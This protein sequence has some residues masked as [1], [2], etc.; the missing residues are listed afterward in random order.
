LRPPGDGRCVNIEAALEAVAEYTSQRAV[1][2]FVD[3]QSLEDRLR[4]TPEGV[5]LVRAVKDLD[6]RVRPTGN[7]VVFLASSPGVP[8]ELKDWVTLVETPLPDARE[9]LAIVQSWIEANCTSVACDLD[10]EGVHALGETMAGMTSRA[11]QSALAKSA[12]SRGGL[13]PCTVEDVLREKVSVIR[14][15]EVL[16]VVPVE[17]TIEDVGGLNNAKEFLVRRKQAFTSAAKRFGLPMF[18]G[19]LLVGVAGTGKSLLAKVTAS[20][21]QLPLL[22]FD[23]GRMQGSL[24]GQS[25][26]RMRRALLLAEAQAPVLL[27]VDEIEKAFAGVGG[28]AGDGGVLQRQFGYLLNWMQE[29]ESPVVII[30]TANDVRR[31][32]AEFLRKGRFDEIF[33]V[34]LPTAAERAEILSVVLSKYGQPTKGIVVDT[35]VRKLERFTGAEID[36]VVCEAL[37]DAFADQQR[38][39]SVADIER[40]AARTVPLADQ[41][42]DEISGLQQWGRVNARPAS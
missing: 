11:I 35:L 4:Q 22:L 14:S 7:A 41:R 38:P 36:A 12:V 37:Y 20:I 33:F 5:R 28:H 2:V 21:L 13:G 27:W 1:F 9:R 15:S 34:D 3:F 17:Q 29:H 40:A 23:I 16:R 8:D 32:P 24:V 42:R 30:A 31:L 19:I 6:E 39:L 10:E 25:E 18:K 26:E